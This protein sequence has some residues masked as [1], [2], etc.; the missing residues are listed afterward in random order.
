MSNRKHQTKLYS[1]VVKNKYGNPNGEYTII[2]SEYTN[3]A[4]F[5]RDLRAN[6]YMVN[7]ANVRVKEVITKAKT[8]TPRITLLV[9]TVNEAI[10]SNKHLT[11]TVV[12]GCMNKVGLALVN[13]KG[14]ITVYNYWLNMSTRTEN[15]FIDEALKLAKKGKLLEY[16]DFV[17]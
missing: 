1:A 2:E 11:A 5:I 7:P 16:P 8:L 17:A 3:K 10:L 14:E 15:D 12:K 6:G 9:D 13:K 4:D